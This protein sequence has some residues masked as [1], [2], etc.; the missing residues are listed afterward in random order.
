M[1]SDRAH[2][3]TQSGTHCP[4]TEAALTM[5]LLR[6]EGLLQAST[7]PSQATCSKETSLAAATAKQ[8]RTCLVQRSHHSLRAGWLQVPF[9]STAAPSPCAQLLGIG[10]TSCL[11][12]A[13]GK[14]CRVG[15]ADQ[16]LG[17]A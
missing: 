4:S 1:L 8:C 11:L 12:C 10:A 15:R 16:G 5:S 17:A 13:A 2:Q 6:R 7:G 14:P 3:H 9:S